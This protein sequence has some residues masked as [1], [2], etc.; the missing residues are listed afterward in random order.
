MRKSTWNTYR[1]AAYTYDVG[2][3]QRSAGGVHLHQ[4]RKHKGM[5]QKR[6]L[7]SNGNFQSDSVVDFLTD[8]GGEAYYAMAVDY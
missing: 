5:W 3:D 1:M 6:I 7:Q 2:Q 4:V 8:E